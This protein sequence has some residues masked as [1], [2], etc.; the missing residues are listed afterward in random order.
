MMVFERAT[1]RPENVQFGR[2]FKG[3]LQQDILDGLSLAG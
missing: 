1:L 2:H 3:Q